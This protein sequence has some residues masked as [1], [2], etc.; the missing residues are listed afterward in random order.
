MLLS[1]EFCER[2]HKA[3][4]EKEGLVAEEAIQIP[5]SEAADKQSR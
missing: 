2:N 4:S 1:L 3:S 5:Q